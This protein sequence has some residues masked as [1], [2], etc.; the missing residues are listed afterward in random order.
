MKRAVLL[1]FVVLNSVLI[2]AQDASQ[3]FNLGNEFYQKS[4]YDSALY[5][6]QQILEQGKVSPALYYNL[7]N[8][9]YKKGLLG[10]A[11]LYY[12]KAAL[13]APDDP[14]INQNLEIARAR[15]IDKIDPLPQIFYKHWISDLKNLFSPDTWSI[16]AVILLWLFFGSLAVYLLARQSGIRKS[17]FALAVVFLIFFITSAVIAYDRYENL[18]GGNSAIIFEQSVYVKSSPEEKSTNLFMLHE[19]TKVEVMDEL[20]NWR[21]IRIA[22]GSIGWIKENAIAVI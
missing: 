6:Y 20:S 17:F 19:G 14:E 8:T 22:N 11:I 21:K 15:T 9:Y 10:E 2:Y 18:T 1:F 13:L 12:E 4:E 7:G 16:I 3:N 5:Y